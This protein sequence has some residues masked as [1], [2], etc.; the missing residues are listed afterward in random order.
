MGGGKDAKYSSFEEQ[1]VAEEAAKTNDST[2]VEPV[3]NPTVTPEQT[4]TCECKGCPDCES[5]KGKV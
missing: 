2:V 4:D 1:E 5:E 3:A